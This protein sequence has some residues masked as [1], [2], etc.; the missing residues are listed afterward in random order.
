MAQFPADGDPCLAVQLA[1]LR[2]Q[3]LAVWST[4][5][6]AFPAGQFLV[7]ILGIGVAQAV[8]LGQTG[9]QGVALIDAELMHVVAVAR[10]QGATAG[11][12]VGAV[13]GFPLLLGPDGDDPLLAALG[14][15]RLE[16]K[17]VTPVGEAWLEFHR[18]FPAQAEGLLQ[19][20]AHA[21]VFI[22]NLFELL[23]GHHLSLGFI[24]DETP[25][26]DTVVF[27]GTRHHVLLVNLVRPPTNHGHAVLDSPD[28]QA[29]G[30][31]VLD[32]GI[33]VFWFQGPI[34]H[35]AIAKVAELIGYQGQH[36]LAFDL[37]GIAAFPALAA[38]FLE[39]VVQVSHSV[40]AFWLVF[41][42]YLAAVADKSA[43]AERS[44][45]TTPMRPDNAWSEAT[46][47][48]LC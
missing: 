26:R 39:L 35:L 16:H 30:E 3:R 28:R 36:A 45:G 34:N 9:A 33:D 24:G 41:L 20:Q 11:K 47:I 8:H 48:F 29:L 38:Q 40:L 6:R 43:D 44:W 10:D 37:G 4:G 25:V 13:E 19:F 2:R 46:R 1:L 31:P 23:A 7:A 32:Q 27:V 22:A 5:G 42:T 21:Y 17:V 14:P 12:S 18:L 15:A